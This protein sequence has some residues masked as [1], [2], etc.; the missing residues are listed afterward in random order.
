M[1]K[2]IAL[3]RLKDVLNVDSINSTQADFLATHVPFRKIKVT[4]DLSGTPTSEYISEDNVFN[5][6]FNNSN[7]YNEHQLIVVD[8]SSGSGKSHFIRWIE[9]NFKY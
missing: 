2:Q 9:A 3:T 5:Q 4:N 8:G 6:Y 1:N 7:M